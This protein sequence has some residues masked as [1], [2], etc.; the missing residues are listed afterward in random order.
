MMVRPF[1]HKVCLLLAGGIL[2]A[3]SPLFSLPFPTQP[4]GVFNTVV[5]LTHD[6]A[7]TQT[8][9][10]LP[11]ATRTS[12]ATPTPRYTPTI[13]P[14]P[15]ATIIFFYYTTTPIGTPTPLPITEWPP[16]TEGTV[17]EMPKGSGE[18]IGTTK[19]FNELAG[20]EMIVTRNNGVKLRS[21]PN[22]AIGGD[23]VLKGTKLILTGLMNK[24]NEFG[25]LFVKVKTS[26]GSLAWVGG[27]EGD[28]TDPRE[29]LEFALVL[30]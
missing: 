29:C 30:E 14:T 24:N 12:T 8:A 23:N 2:L 22:K 17:V 3:C 21:I 27:S 10:F 5:V 9:A 19:M 11:K 13:T 25:W 1:V 15:T 4:A 26:G 16:W 6:A 28:D 7:S 18:T 20:V